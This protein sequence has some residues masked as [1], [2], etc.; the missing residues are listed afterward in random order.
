LARRT[1]HVAGDWA[2]IAVTRAHPKHRT[3][4]RYRRV[5]RRP[6]PAELAGTA[7]VVAKTAMV[8][9]QRS[10]ELNHRCH[11]ATTASVSDRRGGS[12][13][14]RPRRDA[15]A[16]CT[17]RVRGRARRCTA[18]ARRRRASG[19]L[20]G[21]RAEAE[22]KAPVAEATPEELKAAKRPAEDSE[23]DPKKQKTENGDNGDHAED[24]EG[25]EEGDEGEEEED[26]GEE[27]EEDLEGE[28]LEDEDEGEG[29]DED[30]G[31]G[32]EDE[33]EEEEGGE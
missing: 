19:R 30:E 22:T 3:S 13:G 1:R 7:A 27:D 25:E 5:G 32:E 11:A 31:E 20:R 28:G 24:A 21:S 18:C 12:R 14:R 23:T 4:Q 33:G 8:A 26:I 17:R 6:A 9:M 10:V 16:R 15:A 2:A 29:E